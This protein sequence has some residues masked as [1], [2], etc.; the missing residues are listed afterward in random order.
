MGS[1]SRPSLPVPISVIVKIDALLESTKRS[2]LPII[3]VILEADRLHSALPNCTLT[4]SEL[5]GAIF[6][7]SRRD[8]GIGMMLRGPTR[9]RDDRGS[10]ETT[11]L[12][13]TPARPSARSKRKILLHEPV[14]RME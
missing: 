5:A 2:G 6:D 4:R 13:L 8:P 14:A 10:V 11:V 1:I 7:Q 3:D 12:R 9:P